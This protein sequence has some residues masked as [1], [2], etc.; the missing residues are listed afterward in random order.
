MQRSCDDCGETYEAKRP[1]SKYC[2]DTCRKRS[3]RKPKP[4]TES[5]AQAAKDSVVTPPVTPP[6][7]E[8]LAELGL[9]E[10]Y[11]GAITLGLAAQLDGGAIVG[12]QY[13]SLSKEVDRR[14]AELRKMAVVEH[15][16]VAAAQAAVE[17]KR[18]HVV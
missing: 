14:V 11:E 12:T 1:T 7:L 9:A 3:S 10:T 18:L 8:L 13:V 15:D 16:P 6:L 2:R 17:E 5:S 4:A